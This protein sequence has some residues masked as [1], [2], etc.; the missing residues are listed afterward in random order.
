[1]IRPA[2]LRQVVSRE[3]RDAGRTVFGRAVRHAIEALDCGH[4]RIGP[5]QKRHGIVIGRKRRCY[6]CLEEGRL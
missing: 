6:R 4:Q 2:P 5:V 3:L 1:M